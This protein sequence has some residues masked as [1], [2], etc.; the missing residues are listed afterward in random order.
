MRITKEVLEIDEVLNKKIKSIILQIGNK[1]AKKR[2][3]CEIKDFYVNDD[4]NKE[5][6]F[7]VAIDNDKAKMHLSILELVVIIVKK[8]KQKMI[9]L[10][11]EY[12]IILKKVIYLR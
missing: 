3:V 8:I 6:V 10:I 12:R 5:D 9:I 2:T 1:E 7:D 4:F 11:L